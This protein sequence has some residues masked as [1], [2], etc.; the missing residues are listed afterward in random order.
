MLKFNS[1]EEIKNEYILYSNDWFNKIKNSGKELTQD[2]ELKL[3]HGLIMCDNVGKTTVNSGL[4]NESYKV[5]GSIDGLLHD[6]GRFP[7]YFEIGNL[8]DN[9]LN[10]KLGYLDHGRYGA[11]YLEK[12]NYKLLKRF[13]GN[14]KEY[15]NILI[16][17]VK[18]H[19]NLLNTNY[20]FDLKELKNIFQNYDLN[21]V[22]TKK[23]MI[24]RLIALKLLI[25]KEEDS[26]EILH[27]IEFGLWKPIICSN[28]NQYIN[29]YAWN[30]FINQRYID[31]KDLKEKK[32]WNPNIGCLIR[33]S[34][35]YKNINFVGTLKTLIDNNVIDK[36]YLNQINNSKDE[37]G[38]IDLNNIDPRIKDSRDYIKLVIKN[39][40][41][42]SDG[43]IITNE[44]K[45]K[46]KEKT[47]KEFK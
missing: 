1:I 28:K 21:E 3:N 13:I 42:Y 6:V 39:M 14:N 46:A 31:I 30:L 24:N 27:K 8:Y 19:T 7:Q 10:E 47:L 38:N 44:V 18:E 5:S 9:C 29:D 36:V 43:K 25:L 35:I 11:Y 17:V 33:Y 34:L 32:L 20:I 15:Y 37:L 22:I 45:E 41:E 2:I 16:E 23:D 26:L 40:I 4:L 12:E